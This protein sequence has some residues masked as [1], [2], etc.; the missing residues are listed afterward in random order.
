M[1]NKNMNYE[2]YKIKEDVPKVSFV[3][4][5]T[6][7]E[8]AERVA[9]ELQKSAPRGTTFRVVPAKTDNND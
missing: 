1:E 9:A 4:M 3:A 6:S 5:C 7:K 2:I 8:N